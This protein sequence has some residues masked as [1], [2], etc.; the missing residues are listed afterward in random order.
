M[1]TINLPF[2]PA[3]SSTGSISVTTS[4]ASVAIPTSN[5]NQVRIVNESTD[6]IAYI[7]FGDSSVTAATTDMPIL[8][9]TAE[10]FTVSGTHVA[11]I[12]A[13]GT[14]TIKV[15]AGTGA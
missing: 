13:S 5:G 12:T 14:A 1:G 7:A 10:A 3:D 4:S 2:G 8:A 9:S 6:T 11:A 15:T